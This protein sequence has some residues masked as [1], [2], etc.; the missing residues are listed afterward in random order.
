[1]QMC[2]RDYMHKFMGKSGLA[3]LTLCAWF[4][5]GLGQRFGGTAQMIVRRHPLPF[6][7]E[8]WGKEHDR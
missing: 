6:G 3:H 5:K 7:S 1:M 8:K 4:R 2:E